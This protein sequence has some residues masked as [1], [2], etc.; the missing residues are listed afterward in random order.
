M[1]DTLTEGRKQ[2][3]VGQVVEHR[4]YG[5]R[6]VIFGSDSY[7]RGDDAWYLRN[8]TQPEKNQPWYH[9]MVDGHEHTTYVA[10]ENLMPNE[11]PEP[12]EHPLLER[13]FVSRQGGRYFHHSFN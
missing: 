10:E 2:F 1:G 5:Y 4:R 6:G 9:V 3:V 8:R 7:F 11:G 12:V 13:F